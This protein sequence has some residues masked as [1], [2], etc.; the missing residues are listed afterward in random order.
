L[1]RETGFEPATLALARRC[2]TTELF[3][4]DRSGLVG[5]DS[6]DEGMKLSSNLA[7][8]TLHSYRY[9]PT[10]VTTGQKRYQKVTRGYCNQVI[11]LLSAYFLKSVEC[12]PSDTASTHRHI[13]WLVF[14]DPLQRILHLTIQSLITL[15]LNTLDLSSLV[16]ILRLCQPRNA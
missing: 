15:H 2:S 1:E 14:N 11:D 3:P 7:G 5:G 4:L 12:S 6:T 9:L 10:F 13:L 16:R 8:H